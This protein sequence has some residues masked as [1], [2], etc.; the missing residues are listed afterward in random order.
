MNIEGEGIQIRQN[1]RTIELENV[2]IQRP[3]ISGQKPEKSADREVMGMFEA[4][5]DCCC[6][7]NSCRL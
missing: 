2:T 1:I 4:L 3:E 6:V 5:E 7:L